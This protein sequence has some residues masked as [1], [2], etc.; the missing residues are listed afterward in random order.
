MST[1]EVLDDPPTFA[2]LLPGPV[3]GRPKPQVRTWTPVPSA[4]N[5][6]RLLVVGKRQPRL[7]CCEGASRVLVGIQGGN[8]FFLPPVAPA[9]QD[10]VDGFRPE[11][12][13]ELPGNHR[14]LPFRRGERGIDEDAGSHPLAE[15]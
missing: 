2:S 5:R 4:R 8:I 14:T 3:I 11:E 9:R 10:P 6:D 1:G 15:T 13:Q 12:R 7:F